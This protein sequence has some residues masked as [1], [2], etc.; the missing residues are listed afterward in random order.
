MATCFLSWQARTASALVSV[1][2]PLPPLALAIVIVFMPLFRLPVSYLPATFIGDTGYLEL[3]YQLPVVQSTRYFFPRYQLPNS[4]VSA[5][6][7]MEIPVACF[8]KYR[9]PVR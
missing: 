7:I 1:D 9:L 2:L 6:Y 5:T 8:A 3:R 4:R